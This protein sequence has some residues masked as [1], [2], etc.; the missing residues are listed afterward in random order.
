WRP[1]EY[2]RVMGQ[3]SLIDFRGGPREIP[4]RFVFG[5]NFS[6]RKGFLRQVGGFH[7]DGEPE[8]RLRFRGDGETSVSDAVSARGMKALF[9]PDASV[10]H[11][12]T[13]G[14][15][16]WQYLY[17]RAYAQGVSDSYTLTRRI[18]HRSYRKRLRNRLHHAA[19]LARE[20]IG[21]ARGSEDPVS[22]IL[23][24]GHFAGFEFHQRAMDEDPA[25]L[26][27]VLKPSY[28]P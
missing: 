24:R 8:H 23:R 4:P 15:L 22:G 21:S 16:S 1:T 27:W 11:T 9:H 26:E 12:V 3:Y 2:G 6:I 18:G 14:R 20:W 19:F 5:C 13:S 28:L 17:K 25:L 7:P 10:L